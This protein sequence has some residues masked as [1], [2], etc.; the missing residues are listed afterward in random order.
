MQ[1]RKILM[2]KF[3]ECIALVRSNDLNLCLVCNFFEDFFSSSGAVQEKKCGKK[4]N[5]IRRFYQQRRPSNVGVVG[6]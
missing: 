1:A 5:P 6:F 3:D 2:Q 4:E